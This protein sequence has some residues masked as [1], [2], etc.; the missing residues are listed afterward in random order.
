ML[1]PLINKPELLEFCNFI[2]KFNLNKGAKVVGLDF[3]EDYLNFKTYIELLEIPNLEIINFFLGSNCSKEFETL[4]S[5]WD[6]KRESGLAFGI[7]LDS[8]N[9]IRKYFH[10]KFK[11]TLDLIMFKKQFLFLNLLK[12]DIN[13]LKRGISYEIFSDSEFYK[14]FYVYIEDPG[15]I[16]KV[17]AYKKLLFNLSIEEIEELEL[18]ATDKKFKI[19]I[20]NRNDNFQVKQNVWQTI[21]EK[22]KT[23]LTEYSQILEAEPMYTG[24]TT[25]DI[26]SVYF[27]F[28]NKQNNILNI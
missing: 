19:N 16:K 13:K 4:L 26:V 18:Y 11:E 22:Y 6:N 7:K 20:V 5:Y 9:N 3:K 8:N 25:E 1:K 2:K 28:T 15:H 24:F 27:S 10:I 17:L 23:S 21:P 14:K 12:I